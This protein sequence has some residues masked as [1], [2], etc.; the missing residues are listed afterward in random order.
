VTGN[1]GM[2]VVRTSRIPRGAIFAVALTV[3][4]GVAIF[5]ARAGA[6]PQPTISQVQAQVNSLQAKVDRVGQQ[7]DQVSQN[8]AAAQRRLAQVNRA[9]AGDQARYLRARAQLVQVAVTAYENAGKTSVIGVL[10]AGDPSTVLKQ[11]SLLL[12]QAGTHQAQASEFLAN[13][14]QLAAARMQRQRTEEGIAALQAQLSAQKATLAKL[15]NRQQAILKSLTAAQRAKVAAAAVGGA[16]TSTPAP[17]PSPTGTPTPAPSPTGTP[18]PAPSPSGTPTPAASSTGTQAEKAVA[19]AYAQLG[20]PYVWGAT[21]PDSYDCSGLVQAAWAAAGVSIPRTTYEQ[22]AALPHIAASS[23]QPG[24]LLFYEAEGHV[25]IYVGGGYIIDAP[26]TGLDVE[27]IP[28]S[29]SWYADN[30]DG[31]VRP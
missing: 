29:T 4:G 2:S 16:G 8:L 5:G 17:A 12:Q 20:K 14:H 30:F 11:A 1:M 19:F 22:W 3:A 31:A 28:M 25:A 9:A 15:L 26:T 6:A 10:I 23:I 7:Y 21:G 18:T 13:A 24:D 27:K